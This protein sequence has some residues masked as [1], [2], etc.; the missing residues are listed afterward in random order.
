MD[1]SGIRSSIGTEHPI[2]EKMDHRKIAVRVP[3]MDEVQ[4][5]LSSEPRKPLKP[6]SLRV[7]LIVDNDVRVERHRTRDDRNYEQINRQ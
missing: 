6:R 2:P 3:V 4:F 5:L 7:V 1:L